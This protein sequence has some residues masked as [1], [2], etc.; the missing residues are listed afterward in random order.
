M[1]DVDSAMADL[2]LDLGAEAPKLNA[3]AGD[4]AAAAPK[5]TRAPRVQVKLGEVTIGEAEDLADITRGGGAE[6]RDSKYDF[7]A[8]IPEPVQ[9]EDGSWNYFPATVPL[10]EDGDVD[11]LKRAINSAI[12]GANSKSKEAGTPNHYV[13]RSWIVNGEFKGVKIYR[14]D[15][16]LAKKE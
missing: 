6:G 9:K 12:S 15:A 2:G 4:E 16:T 13:S 1:S 10:V 7:I 14:V 5:K 3:T 8:T 11:A